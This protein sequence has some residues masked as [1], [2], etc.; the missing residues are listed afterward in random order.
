[1]RATIN[2]IEM[3]YEVSG[4][5]DAPAVVLHHPLATNLSTWDALTAALEPNYR[6]VRFDARG[7]GKTEAPEG[8]Y[9][10]ET[11][12]A[13]VVGLMDHLGIDKARFLGLSMGGM[14]GQ[15]LGILYP[16]RFHC[17]CLVATTSAVPAQAHPL[18]DERIR[19]ASTGSL[20]ELVEGAIVRWVVPETKTNKP[21]VV[22]QLTA[23]MEATPPK[24]YIGWC[25]AIRNLNITDR[26]K[27]IRVPTCVI[28]GE[29]DPS[30]PPAAAEV[31]H[32]EIAGSELVVIP[33]V[34][35]MLHLEDPEAFHAKVLPFFAAHG[36]SA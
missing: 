24:G 26:L 12:A 29:S 2:G 21:E 31:I 1:M 27:E 9:A 22:A 34:S 7:H 19:V 30:T 10:F 6:V 14:V 33:G 13:D 20:S 28:V 15:Y 32:R 25:Q 4:R 18:W 35:H 17:L 16:D 8:P 11:L 5:S 23:M 36:P 3:N